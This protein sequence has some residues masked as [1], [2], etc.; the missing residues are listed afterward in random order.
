M[1]IYDY[2]RKEGAKGCPRC[3]EGFEATQPMSAEPLAVC[4]SCGGAV[5]RVISAPA[6]LKSNKSILSDKNL[7]R[8]G[9]ERLV[10]E[11]KGRYRRTT[12]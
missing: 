7:K 6:I 1:P 5:E 4:P 2:R 3:A 12:T 9:F 11:D 8:H 10:K